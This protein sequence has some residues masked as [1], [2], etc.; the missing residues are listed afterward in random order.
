MVGIESS[1][2]TD[3]LFSGKRVT[4]NI[5]KGTDQIPEDISWIIQVEGHTDKRPIKTNKFPSNW[6]LSAARAAVVVRYLESKGVNPARLV[7][8]GYADRWPADM[9]WADMRRGSVQKPVGD[10]ITIETGRSGVPNYKG[11]ERDENNIIWDSV[12]K[13][14]K[15]PIVSYFF[16]N[17]SVLDTNPSK[18]A[19]NLQ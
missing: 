13:F 17:H 1:T 19:K 14:R 7:A 6:E 16:K 15:H 9:T 12:G 4:A 2:S 10:N 11:V 8:H 3:I 18:S 5:L